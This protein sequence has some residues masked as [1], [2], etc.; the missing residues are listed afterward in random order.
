MKIL[1]TR[2][3]Y[4]QVLKSNMRIARSLSGECGCYYTETSGAK[5]ERK[6]K[7]EGANGEMTPLERARGGARKV[8][9][10]SNVYDD[11]F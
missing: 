3:A 7:S 1:P 2:K 10:D 5:E 6:R 9:S 11:W 4:Q 8:M